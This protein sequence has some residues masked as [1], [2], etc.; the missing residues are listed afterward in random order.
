[1][2]HDFGRNGEYLATRYWNAL[3]F[4][5]VSDRP[6]FYGIVALNGGRIQEKD[7]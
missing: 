7:V 4:S 5:A 6:D 2:A 1:M 3:K